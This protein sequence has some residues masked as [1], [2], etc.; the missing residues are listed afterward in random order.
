MRPRART[1][2][3]P[4]LIEG[5]DSRV[6]FI[7]LVFSTESSGCRNLRKVVE[8]IQLDIQLNEGAVAH[9][10]LIGISKD[11]EHEIHALS[12]IFLCFLFCKGALSVPLGSHLFFSQSFSNH[13]RVYA[14]LA[15]SESL[16]PHAGSRDDRRL[17]A[18]PRRRSCGLACRVAMRI[19]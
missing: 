15:Q 18:P 3:N 8:C 17:E 9:K 16:D 11:S 7:W 13:S 1:D 6:C 5:K 14:A 10:S 4:N 2:R 19:H 12:H